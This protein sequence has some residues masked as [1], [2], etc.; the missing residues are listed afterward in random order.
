[1]TS[2]ML[3]PRRRAK[4]AAAPLMD[5]EGSVLATRILDW[6]SPSVA[7]LL[8]EPS[9]Q[10]ET[11][12]ARLR[13]THRFIAR[14]IR[15]VYAVNDTQPVSRTLAHRRGSCSQRLA[16]LEAVARASGIETR[17]R[18]I[19]VAGS[20]W[21]PRFPHLRWAVPDLVVL[22]WPEFMIEDAWVSVSELFGSVPELAACST[23]FN[24]A[25]GE[26]LFDAISRTAVDWDGVSSKPGQASTC[27]LSATVRDDLGYFSSRDELF[28]LHGQTLCW[29]ARTVSGP[30]LG[31]RSAGLG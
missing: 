5:A 17:V 21:Y 30:V 15:P 1:M 7:T 3:M 19:R 6:N 28:D 2:S 11:G 9:I 4:V 13:A 24:N 27:D 8:S 23:G 12:I 16:I 18:G 25:E 31:H 26:T 22:A 14:T 10:A 20:F 29:F